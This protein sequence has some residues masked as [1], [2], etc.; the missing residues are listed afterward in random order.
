EHGTPR[1]QAQPTFWRS[2]EAI[3]NQRF[4][5][6]C[7]WSSFRAG[8]L[9][10]G[11]VTQVPDRPS[12]GIPYVNPY[13]KDN[14]RYAETFSDVWLILSAKYGFLKPSFVIPGAYEVTFKRP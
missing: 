6:G 12:L 4:C 13:F 1:N 8:T 7:G 3:T 2:Q 11:S 10:S 5:R 9:S 14:R